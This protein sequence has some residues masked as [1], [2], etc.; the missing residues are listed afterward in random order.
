MDSALAT[1]LSLE[2]Y[3]L[4]K[5]KTQLTAANHLKP[6]SSER[7]LEAW[8]VL[9][10]ELMG[11]EGPRQEEEFN[12]IAELPKL[13]SSDMAKFDNLFVRWESELKKHETVSSDYVIGKYR[14]RQIVYKALPDEIQRA[15]DAEVAKGQ[16]ASY[17]EFIEFVKIIARSSRFKSLPAPKPLSAN[18]VTD[19]PEAPNYSHEEWV[20]YLVSD[21]GW[22]AFQAGECPPPDALREVLTLVGGDKGKGKSFGKGG[23]GKQGKS[24]GKG[25][26]GNDKGAG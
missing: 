7:G 2:M 11:R 6:I 19:E 16:I 13:K 26:F 12:A 22:S 9:R 15:V 14:R 20:C 23:F 3:V 5:M 1:K 17:E 25:G 10:R 4:L 24:F 21:E 18:L 8:R